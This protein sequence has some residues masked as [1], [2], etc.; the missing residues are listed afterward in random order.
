MPPIVSL[1][2]ITRTLTE[3]DCK[4]HLA[5]PLTMPAGATRLQVKLSF[6][7]LTVEGQ[8]GTNMLCLSLFDPSGCRGAGHARR[9]NEIDLSAVYA[10]PGYV[11]GPLAAGAWD[12]TVDV[13]MVVPTSHVTY[14]L[15]AEVS[16]EPQ[17][18]TA[19]QWPEG[20]LSTRGAGWYRGNL[21]AH[22]IHSDGSWDVPDV[23]ASARQA[24]MDFVALTDHNTV[25]PLAQMRSYGTDDLCI[26]GGMELTTYYGH[27]VVVGVHRWVDWRTQTTGRN[28]IAIAEEVTAAGGTFIIAHPM[29]EGD[30]TCTGCDWQYSEM[31]PGIAQIVEVWNGGVWASP[32][33]YND[34]GLAL[35]Y[36]WLNQ[37]HHLVATAGTD[38]HGSEL[39]GVAI[40]LNHVYAEAL[41]ETAILD[42]VRVGH[43]YLSSGPRVE[44]TGQTATARAICGDTLPA[45]PLT[46]TFTWQYVPAQAELRIIQD[47][48]VVYTQTLPSTGAYLWQVDPN[49]L[50]WCTVE[51]RDADNALLT[52]TN[53]IFIAGA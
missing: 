10:T 50:R 38:V 30:P 2:D 24:G 51:I 14:H 40:G 34:K 26:I 35:W 31:K 3:A 28:I 5:H 45:E 21:H 39:E 19:P 52:V 37:G 47:G 25:S 33:Q 8:A 17:A 4:T 13:H 48:G 41:T 7:P 18:G 32:D 12:V 16:F 6:S 11:A 53:P 9:N 42:A 1:L 49:M 29:S 27:A 36:E 46:F 23:I 43:N 15:T 20:I 44:F 22:T